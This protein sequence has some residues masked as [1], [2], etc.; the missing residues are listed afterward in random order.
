MCVV[1][2]ATVLLASSSLCPSLAQEAEKP[3]IAAPQTAP[4]Q[5]DQNSQQQREQRTERGRPREDDREIGRDWRMRRGDGERMGRED[6][7]TGPEW[8]RHR[9]RDYDRE[10]DKDRDR[11][12][13]RDN[14]G[15]RDRADRGR[16]DSDYYDEVRPRRRVKICIERGRILPLR[17]SLIGWVTGTSAGRERK[18]EYAPRK[19]RLRAAA[20]TTQR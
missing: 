16:D 5:P 20:G 12:S 10:R 11:Y 2:L 13:D 9:D 4:S 19:R 15:G 8:G 3:T 1:I 7:D 14:R 6:R 18:S 17:R